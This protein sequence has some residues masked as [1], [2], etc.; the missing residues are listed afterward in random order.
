MHVLRPLTPSFVIQ[1]SF[2]NSLDF[3]CLGYAGIEFGASGMLDGHSTTELQ[4]QPSLGTLWEHVE[5]IVYVTTHL[6]TQVF[7]G[8]SQKWETSGP[9]T[10]QDC[11]GQPAPPTLL[12]SECLVY[13]PWLEKSP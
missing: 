5:L 13:F 3:P 11:E 1:M 7:A 2:T 10:S 12:N 4:P 8:H 6:K 9:P